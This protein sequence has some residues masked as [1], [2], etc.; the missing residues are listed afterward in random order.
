LITQDQLAAA[1]EEQK[2]SGDQLGAVLVARGFVPSALVAQALATQSGSILKTEY[3]FATGFGTTLLETS[4]MD[5]PP[6]SPAVGHPVAVLAPVTSAPA[7]QEQQPAEPESLASVV[8]EELE[9][10]SRETARLVEANDRLVAL[11]AELEQRLA[12][13]SQRVTALER[14]LA[15]L[16]AAPPSREPD[17]VAWQAAH[18]QAE[19]AVAQWQAAYAELEKQLRETTEHAALLQ[20]DLEARVA[21]LAPAAEARDE[22]QHRLANVTARAD[23]LEAQ[24]AAGERRLAAES[25]ASDRVQA[26]LAERLD[27]AA[28]QLRDSE[29]VRA[30]LE[31]HCAE[32]AESAAGFEALATEVEGLRRSAAE[33]ERCA[34]ELEQSLAHAVAEL[35]ELRASESRAPWAGAAAHCVFF[36]GTQGYELIE[37][38]G[39]PPADGS[40]VVLP[41]GSSQVVARVGASPFPG[42][43]LPCAYLVSS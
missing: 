26:E 4:T 39:P 42:S 18:T 10:A 21:V 22:L 5:P 11:R 35:A 37:R 19:Q 31:L 2:I 9:L 40:R 12:R 1:L 33:S 8:R 36:Q 20:E 38:E 41:G 7:R 32:R 29:A 14:E 6:V 3:G 43:V 25:S 30:A 34:A 23:A 28:A 17:L 24:V 13:E 16:Q 27:Q 15:E